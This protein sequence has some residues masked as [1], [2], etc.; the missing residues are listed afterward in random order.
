MP[1]YSLIVADRAALGRRSGRRS[2]GTGARRSPRPATR[3]TT[4]RAPP[5]G[6]SSSAGAAP[7]TASARAIADDHDRHGPTHAMLRRMVRRVVPDAARTSRFTHAWGGPLGAPRDWMPT[8]AYD[9]AGGLRHRPRL[10]RPGR[11]HRQPRRPRPGRPDRRR[12]TPPLTRLPM[13]NHR[14]PDW[15]PEPLRW[16]GVRFVQHGYAQLDRQAERTGVAPSGRSAGRAAGQ[17]LSGAV[18]PPAGSRSPGRHRRG[19]GQTRPTT[20]GG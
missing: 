15:E 12:R 14:S 5:T 3:S 10:H 13:V 16:L 11:R 7:P 1:V 4:S 9:P 2:A 18:G 19:S 17:P 6:G 8:V 20:T